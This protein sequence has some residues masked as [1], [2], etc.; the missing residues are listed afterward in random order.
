MRIRTWLRRWA[1]RPA[2]RGTAR[3]ACRPALLHLEVRDVPAVV[4]YYDMLAGQ[5]V[6]SQVAP[7]TA[8]GH[9]AVLLTDL[10]AADLAGIDV[11]FVQNP[12]NA[13]YGAEYLSRLDSIQSAVSN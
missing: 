13:G 12:D 5:G 9:T 4:G 2:A 11:L 6:P 10:T 7:I 1:G 3:R 8:A